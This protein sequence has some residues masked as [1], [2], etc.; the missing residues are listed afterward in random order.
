ML[1]RL[2]ERLSKPSSS[3]FW[4]LVRYAMAGGLAFGVDFALLWLATD[5]L[6][7]HYLIGAAIGYAAG[8]VITYLLSIKWIFDYRRMSSQAAEFGV[9]TLIGLAGLLLTQGLMY[10]F[11]DLWLGRDL[12]LISK[13]L[14]TVIVSL[15]NFG[16]KKL[17]LFRAPGR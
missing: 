3:V 4:Q 14:T 16:A 8:L 11:T 13:V 6:G 2:A 5:V 15:F 12:Y 10:L 7:L 1:Q 17:L 9:F